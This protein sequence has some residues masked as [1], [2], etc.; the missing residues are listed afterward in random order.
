MQ[1]VLVSTNQTP[2]VAAPSRRSFAPVRS[3][4]LE[5]KCACGGTPGPTG[6]CELD[7]RVNRLPT[8]FELE[9]HDVS[10]KP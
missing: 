9:W 3:G 6:E 8:P 7:E 5:R 4:L 1:Q 2:T 10:G